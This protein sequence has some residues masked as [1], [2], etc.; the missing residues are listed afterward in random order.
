M[1]PDP[2]DNNA[3]ASPTKGKKG[4]DNGEKKGKGGKIVLIVVLLLIIMG[5]AVIALDIGGVRSETIMPY[6]RN[7]PLIGSFFPEEEE[8]EMDALYEMTE[9]EMRQEIINLRNQVAS[10]EN[11]RSELNIQLHNAQTRIA[12]LEEFEMRW[13]EYRIASARFTQMLAHNDP[14]NFVEFFYDIVEHD[15]VPADILAAIFGEAMAINAYDAEFRSLLATYNNMEEDRAAED[16]ERLLMINTPLAV[17]LVRAMGASRRAVIFDSM[18]ATV[19]TT[20]TNL[21]SVEPPTF[22]PLVPP[23]FLPEIFPPT[24]PPFVPI[25]DLDDEEYEED[26][27]NGEEEYEEYEEEDEE[28][29]AAPPADEETDAG[30]AEPIIDAD[31]GFAVEDE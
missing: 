22:A 2:L 28:E 1:P 15:L 23:P 25:D 9:E 12:H 8:Y 13:N 26:E 11:Q 29:P 30:E 27:E 14:I 4:G 5:I 20:F 18:E 6:L 19:S 10:L 16:L 21:I 7:A 17:R 24:P 3:A 31:E